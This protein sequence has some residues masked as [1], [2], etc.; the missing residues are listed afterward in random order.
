MRVKVR[1]PSTSANLGPGFDSLGLALNIDNYVQISPLKGAE[2][3]RNQVICEVF[4]GDD[5]KL[6][7]ASEHNLIRKTL[8]HLRRYTGSELAGVR[9]EQ[10]LYRSP[11]RGMGSSA[12]AIVG[13]LMA[14]GKYFELGLSTAELL[15]LACRIESHP[16]NVVPALLGG[17]T[18][19]SYSGEGKE[20]VWDR[21]IPHGSMRLVAVIP[22]LTSNTGEQ[23]KLI[24]D[25][26]RM[27]D[28]CHNLSRTAL[29]PLAFA[30]GDYDKLRQIM[31][32]R[33]HQPYRCAAISG[34]DRVV[35]A[36]YDSGAQGIALSGAGP[37]ILAIVRDESGAVGRSMVRA[38]QRVG[39][40]SEYIVTRPD[41]KGSYVMEEE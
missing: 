38:W 39:V 16:D 12:V 20:L 6:N 5:K 23:R 19:S 11:A 13:T 41:E 31:K 30:S 1:V 15:R 32:D 14:A 25:K 35:A 27:E 3:D 37:T 17:L 34:W 28:I 36:G 9:V 7:I 24:P 40:D 21:V 4:D 26:F 8:R 33:L 29:L 22:E 18:V 2:S 10:K